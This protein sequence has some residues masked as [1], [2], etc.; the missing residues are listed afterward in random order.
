MR[1]IGQA[2]TLSTVFRRDDRKALPFQADLE[3]GEQRPIIVDQQDFGFHV[4]T[5]SRSR[6]ISA[7]G[8]SMYSIT[9]TLEP[10]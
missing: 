8:Y 3:Q 6:W 10:F 7:P 4:Y 1:L 2:E 5:L 9:T